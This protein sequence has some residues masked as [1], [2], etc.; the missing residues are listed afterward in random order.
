MCVDPSY[1]ILH[2]SS[3]RNCIYPFYH[4][5]NDPFL[6]PNIRVYFWDQN[7]QVVF[8]TVVD[9]MEVWFALLP[10]CHLLIA[11][12]GGLHVCDNTYRR[13]NCEEFTVR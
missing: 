10:C 1:S 11:I 5:Y 2:E 13:R 6:Q 3:D 8:G 9:S 12:L 7:G 4:F